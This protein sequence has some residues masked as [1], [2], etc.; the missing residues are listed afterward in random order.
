MGRDVALDL[1]VAGLGTL[2]LAPSV[3]RFVPRL[4]GKQPTQEPLGPPTALP[5]GSAR[6]L[7]LGLAHIRKRRRSGASTQP[8]RLAAGPR[9]SGDRASV[10]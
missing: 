10:S 7:R 3:G 2:A 8:D 5:L 4:V 1:V 9:S 6:W